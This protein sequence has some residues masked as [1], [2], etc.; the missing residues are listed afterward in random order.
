M[1]VT[2]HSLVLIEKYKYTL[3]EAK[4]L[5]SFLLPMLNPYPHQRVEAQQALKHPWLDIKGDS[6]CRMTPE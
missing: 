1:A 2:N 6:D 3:A 5:S 4:E